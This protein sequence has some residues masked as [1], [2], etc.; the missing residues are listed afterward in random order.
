MS[1]KLERTAKLID[2]FRGL[3]DELS[4]LS[5]IASMTATLESDFVV[6]AMQIFDRNM[7]N[8]RIAE[9]GTGKLLGD[10]T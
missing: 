1:T 2:S 8:M 3:P 10:A 5:A 6:I 9:V 7:I 4:R